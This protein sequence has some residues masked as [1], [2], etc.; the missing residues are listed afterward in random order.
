MPVIKAFSSATAIL[1]IESQIK[2]L[3]GIKYLVPG[4]I[5]SVS[6]LSSRIGEANMADLVMGICAIIFLL[7][8]E[9]CRNSLFSIQFRYDMI[10]DKSVFPAFG[11]RRSLPET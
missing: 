3:L 5:S 4:L 2:V 1:V 7:L 9:V 11:T 10:Y 8:L 6:T